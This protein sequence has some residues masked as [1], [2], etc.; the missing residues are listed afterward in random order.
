MKNSVVTV[1]KA[2]VLVKNVR[3]MKTATIVVSRL[4][5]ELKG[6]HLLQVQMGL[7]RLGNS[8]KSNFMQK[9]AGYPA[10]FFISCFL[11]LLLVFL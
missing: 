5:Q 10:A 11:F 2:F 6:L 8:E 9:A 7:R 4:G 3:S 1:K